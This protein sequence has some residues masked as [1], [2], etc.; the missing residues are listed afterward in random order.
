[1]SMN[2]EDPMIYN[3]LQKTEQASNEAFGTAVKQLGNTLL[4][5]S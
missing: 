2:V 3:Q 5:E 4:R 1:M